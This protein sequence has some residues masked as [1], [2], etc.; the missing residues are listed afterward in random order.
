[1]PLRPNKEKFAENFGG[2]FQPYKKQPT[3]QP[4][5]PYTYQSAKQSLVLIS[6]PNFILLHF[7]QNKK[8]THFRLKKEE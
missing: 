5:V 3:N 4:K 7:G 1:M 2:T 8:K 6:Q